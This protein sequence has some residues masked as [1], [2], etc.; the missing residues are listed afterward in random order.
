LKHNNIQ[1]RKK[2]FEQ[3]LGS[4]EEGEKENEEVS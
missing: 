2:K 3:K 4:S 1:E